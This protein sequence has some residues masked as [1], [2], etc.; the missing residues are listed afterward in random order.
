MIHKKG[1]EPDIK[2]PVSREQWMRVQLRRARVESPALFA[3]EEPPE[4][5]EA[6]DEPLRRAVDLLTAL[7]IV[8][9]QDD[10]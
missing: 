1:L 9:G 8:N 6:V 7:L 4:V 10:S 2:V 3:D 5:T